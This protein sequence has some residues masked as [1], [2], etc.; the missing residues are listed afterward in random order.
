MYLV[1]VDVAGQIYIKSGMYP[2]APPSSSGRDRTVEHN[3]AVL[4]LGDK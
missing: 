4:K 1:S 2:K 3:D